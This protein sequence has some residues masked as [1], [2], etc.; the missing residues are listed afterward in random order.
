M[1]VI[2]QIKDTPVRVRISQ[3]F[4]EMQV[5]F[6]S[7]DHGK[8]KLFMDLESGIFTLARLDKGECL[9]QYVKPWWRFW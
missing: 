6:D 1:L 3:A 4:S 5:E 9:L 8:V 7:V 2:S